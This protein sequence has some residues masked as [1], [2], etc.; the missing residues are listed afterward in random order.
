MPF[1]KN[2]GDAR[3]RRDAAPRRSGA[4]SRARA[5]ISI[6]TSPSTGSASRR[7]RA[8]RC[9]PIFP[10]RRRRLKGSQQSRRHRRSG[11]RRADRH[12][13][14]GATR[15]RPGHRLPRARPRDPRRP[16][17]DPALVQGVA[18]DRLLGRVRPSAGA[19][20]RYCPRHPGD[21]VVRPR[22]GG[23]T[24]AAVELARDPEHRGR[25]GFRTTP[26]LRAVDRSP[27]TG[28]ARPW[29]PISSAAS[30]S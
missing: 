17:L 27:A 14:R 1:I 22:K 24:R 19:S 8:T 15:G 13:H 23:K 20:P 6:S 4:V 10:R 11:D 29:P 5:T 7:R 12:D 25:I 16:L 18:L 9:A 28:R 3:H 2:L 30:C 21:L 26:R